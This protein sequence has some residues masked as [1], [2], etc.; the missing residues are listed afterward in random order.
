MS[1]TALQQ[2]SILVPA[3]VAHYHISGLH[4]LRDTLRQLP[5]AQVLW[6]SSARQCE[7]D[8]KLIKVWHP[9]ILGAI[10]GIDRINLLTAAA[11][12][13][14]LEN[15]MYNGWLHGHYISY[16]LLFSLKGTCS[17][18]QALHQTDILV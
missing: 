7:E 18:C 15:A 12:D 11:D 3:T 16:M 4:I 10:G 1:D 5:E 8:A 17:R 6:W 14:G 13:P 2:I 9:M